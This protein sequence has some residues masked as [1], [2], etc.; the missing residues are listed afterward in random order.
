MTETSPIVNGLVMIHKIIT[1]SLNVALQKCN[2][3]ISLKGIPAHEARGYSM[4]LANLKQVTHSHHSSEDEIAFPYF[5]EHIEA[6]YEQL[7]DDHNS[8]A[9]VLARLDPF[10]KEVSFNDLTSLKEVLTEF[11]KL[12]FPHIRI[13]EE[14]FTPDRVNSKSAISDQVRMVK[15]LSDHGH[16]NSGPG[17]LVLPFFFYNLEGTDRE[18]F[19]TPFPW[20]LKKFLVP[21]VWKGQ[22]KH[23]AP[24]LLR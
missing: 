21:V 6:P 16:K 2:E 3:Y 9:V 19:M 24:F 15:E 11:E 7:K 20:I 17:P 4:Y 1:R 22:W 8:L 18:I 10:L 23:M 13:E 5:R 12:W 14:N